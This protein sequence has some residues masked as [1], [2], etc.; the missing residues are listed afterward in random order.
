MK[1]TQT[2][3]SAAPLS[4]EDAALYAGWFK[5]LADP[6]RVRVLNLLATVRRPMAVG[7]IVERLP[8][9][10]STVSHHLKVLADVRFVLPERQG[11][12]TRYEVN[13][14]CLECFPAA[15]RAI[16]AQT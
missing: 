8:I 15:V 5:A 3:P 4:P 2:G 14:A 6:M 10:Q 13:D 7:E 12:S 16:M 1:T 11:T 9:S